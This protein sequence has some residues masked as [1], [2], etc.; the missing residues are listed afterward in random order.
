MSNTEY[1]NKVESLIDKALLLNK[2][3]RPD[4]LKKECGDD[5]NL[6]RDATDFLNSIEQ[7][8]SDNFLEGGLQ[9]HFELIREYSE[10][11][12]FNQ[13]PD[14]IGRTIGS[15]KLIE[16]LGEGGMGAVYLAERTD[17]EFEKLVAIKFLKHGLFSPMMRDRFRLEK[18]I[19]S[20]LDHPG[21]ARLYDGGVS[22]DGTP[23]LVM[24]YVKGLPVDQYCKDKNLSIDERIA[25]F[26]KICD[27]VQYAHSH[28]I[29]HRD[30][31]PKNIYITEAGEVKILDFGIA[32]LLTTDIDEWAHLQT[33]QGQ[34]LLSLQ[35]AA[36]EQIT[37]GEPSAATD[38][39]VLG[40]LLYKLLTGTFPFNFKQK[41]R[42][43]AEHI[44][45]TEIPVKPNRIHNKDIGLISED[46]SS[47]IM[48]ALRKE[49]GER[50]QTVFELSG[51]INRY[52]ENLP[53]LA[54]K[55]GLQYKTKKYLQ[56]NKLPLTVT[57]LILFISGGFGVYHLNQINQQK[58][59]A[60]NEAVTAQLVT[61]YMIDLFA[62]ANPLQN[63][64]DTLT[65]YD[66]LQTGVE[67]IDEI[68]GQPV[69]QM[70]L[71]TAI[72]NSYL[73]LSDYNSAA[74]LLLRADS[75]ANKLYPENSFETATSSLH[76]A[77]LYASMRD[78]QSAI[79]YYKKSLNYFNESSK[80]NVEKR[81]IALS[82][83]GD[84]YLETGN[85][86]S[87]ITLLNEALQISPN[88]NTDLYLSILVK[89]AKAYRSIGNFNEAEKIYLEIIDASQNT[90]H[91]NY[92]ILPG[93]LNNLA[94]L[95]KTQG[96]FEEAKMYYEKALDLHTLVY[97]EKHSNTAM[98]L[99]NLASTTVHLGEYEYTEHLI[100]K[101]IEIKIETAGETSW[102]AGAAYSGIARFY[103]ETGRPEKA[104]EAFEEALRIYNL[105]LGPEHTWTAINHL[106]LDFSLDLA[107]LDNI[108]G[109]HY[110]KGVAILSNR[111]PNLN[112]YDRENFNMLLTIIT[113]NDNGKYSSKLSH[114]KNLFS[115]ADMMND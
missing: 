107:G 78:F 4:F 93:T 6:Y 1:W 92:K 46:L 55:G 106:Y 21:I 89:K 105:A 28:L 59:I 81:A 70:N 30:L 75:L 31:K 111:I 94:F 88:R 25:I 60:Q 24:E 64:Q 98:I 79:P 108:S 97:G 40:I 42:K 102:Q 113:N 37:G 57:L 18:V 65:V 95:L 23:Y 51:D 10:S 76:L 17:G 61:D 73:N 100:K 52:I 80:E 63:I 69:V 47:I 38:V 54:R 101:N 48:K 39:Y 7:A 20:R 8:E 19:L 72:G 14:L 9:S 90:Q 13:P 56:R 58:M 115:Q 91:I 84:S 99:T 29:I 67:K 27:T 11:N 34:F 112:Y 33:G 85:S 16:I 103:L 96:R 68:Q 86:D 104:A 71:L 109:S 2:K 53:V 110:N 5:K 62:S 83:L 43:E 87:S 35:H 77:S 41:T 74:Y 114:L 82:G 36:P 66:L 50:Y 12:S 45:Q 26:K 32:K 22:E 49:P 3:E 15:Y 44:I